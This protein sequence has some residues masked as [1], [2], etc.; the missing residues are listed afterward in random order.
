M[1]LADRHALPLNAPEVADRRLDD[2][3]GY[4][5]TVAIRELPR[6]VSSKVDPSDL[7]QDTFLKAHR[8]AHRSPGRSPAE[9]KA[10]L[11]RILLN[12]LCS[13]TR[14]YRATAKRQVAREV[15]LAAQAEPSARP[16]GTDPSARLT[17]QELHEALGRALER[18]PEQHRQVIRWHNDDRLPFPEIGRRL[19]NSPE[20][21]RKVWERA[22]EKLRHVL[23]PLRESA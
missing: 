22:L 17:D 5:L 19:G 10:W 9:V 7:V 14:H 23:G 13:V 1:I 11:R 18:L 20:A 4:L 16:D 12:H 15:P 21:A 8:A 2:Y 6:D 3:L